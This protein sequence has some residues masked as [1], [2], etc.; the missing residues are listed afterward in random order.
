MAVKCKYV[1]SFS[2]FSSRDLL[3]PLMARDDSDDDLFLNPPSPDKT[4]RQHRSPEIW[5]KNNLSRAADVGKQQD[6]Q[7]RTYSYMSPVSS[8]VDDLSEKPQRRNRVKLVKRRSIKKTQSCIAPSPI[9]RES[10]LEDCFSEVSLKKRGQKRKHAKTSPKSSDP[11]SRKRVAGNAVVCDSVSTHTDSGMLSDMLAKKA[12]VS[13]KSEE[14]F[15]VFKVKVEQADHSLSDLDNS[16]E[17][18]GSMC[19]EEDAKD[20]VVHQAKNGADKFQS[21][22]RH[23][24]S[25]SASSETKEDVKEKPKKR[26][27]KV[28]PKRKAEALKKLLGET[29]LQEQA[30]EGSPSKPR[31][32]RKEAQGRHRAAPIECELCGRSVR[33]KAMLKRHMLSHTGEKPFECNECGKHYTSSSN[34]RIHQLKH[35]GKMDYACNECGQKFTH[36]PYL[37][38]HLLRHTGKKLHI[39]EHCGKGFIQKY[40][41]L[42]HI[43]V[44]TRQ[45]PHVCDKCGMSFNRTDYLRVHLRNVHQVDSNTQKGKPE[46]L[47]KCETCDKY[48]VNHASLEIHKRIHTGAKPYSC[49]ICSRQFKQSGHM[50]S[51]MI[52]HSS[53]KP[54]T[55]KLCQLKFT[56]KSYLRKHK[57]RMHSGD[58]DPQ[59]S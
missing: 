11:E 17:R 34:L 55:C 32:K 25:D 10:E 1:H 41:L 7:R 40:H 31:V 51:H 8:D 20:A 43:L 48:F 46:K 5:S 33:C 29:D 21:R 36:L 47:Y 19:E 24:R 56:R 28:T 15:R 6:D 23:S 42:R 59:S 2:P 54:H 3:A 12:S 35:S 9:K 50:Y 52:T 30:I 37:K 58:A 57:E 18:D 49:I 22:S 4:M 26:R 45:T 14:K 44:H 38:R 16:R 39:C 27:V 13:I 53:E